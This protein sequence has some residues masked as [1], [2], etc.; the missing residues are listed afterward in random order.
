MVFWEIFLVQQSY[1]CDDTTIDCFARNATN[2]TTLPITDCSL[3]EDG[4]TDDTIIIIC[5]TFVYHLGTGLAAAGGM[6]AMIKVVTKVVTEVFLGIY[7]CLCHCSRCLVIFH[8]A[9]NFCLLVVCYLGFVVS[10]SLLFTLYKPL[11]I[12]PSDIIRAAWLFYSV[13]LDSLGL[14]LNRPRQQKRQWRRQ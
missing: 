7:K 8:L 11:I 1:A 2:A 5:Y 12:A 3:Y 10:F 4:D 9:I 14:F 6:I 13:V